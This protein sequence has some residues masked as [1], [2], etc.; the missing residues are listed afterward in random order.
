MASAQLSR[1]QRLLSRASL[2]RL[3]ARLDDDETLV[4]LSTCLFLLTR[5]L[6]A[7]TDRRALFTADGVGVSD[8]WNFPFEAVESVRA[9]PE[10]LLPSFLELRIRGRLARFEGLQPDD[11]VEAI[12][13][14]IAERIPPPA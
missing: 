4:F 9:A 14:Y 3:P 2:N 10:R 6:L 7:V 13:A 1:T 5:G 11:R 12:A 8:V